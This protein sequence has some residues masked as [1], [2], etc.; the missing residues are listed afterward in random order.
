MHNKKSKGPIIYSTKCYDPQYQKPSE[1]HQK[2]HMKS[3]YHQELSLLSQSD[4]IESMKL[5]IAAKC[6]HILVNL[7][8]LN[9]VNYFI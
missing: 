5:N 1:S 8:L 2:Y 3:Y 4:L 9:R 7:Q 6:S